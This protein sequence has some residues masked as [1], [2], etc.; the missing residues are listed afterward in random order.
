MNSATK[1]SESSR[2]PWRGI[3]HESRLEARRESL[4]AAGLE[5]LGTKGWEATTVRAVCAEAG[6]TSRYFY[7]NFGDL[8]DLLVTLFD[9][10]FT[11]TT[12][13]AYRAA[14]ADDIDLRC[15]VRAAV[16]ATIEY[17]TEDPRRLRVLAV[18]AIGNEQ[19]NRRRLDA[20][21][22]LAGFLDA[23]G[24][25][26]YGLPAGSEISRM[27]A[28]VLIGGIAELALAWLDGQF[29][30]SIAELA[31]NIVDLYIAFA[32]TAASLARTSSPP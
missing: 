1:V 25:Q 21:K 10:L 7:E 5:L 8:D 11:E 32:E 9:S 2:R 22:A 20:L 24:Q 19:L 4:L 13:R 18:E 3:A 15:R 6:L 12:A 30:S 31:D 17:V 27:T 16:G 28:H 23:Q 14:I 26:I 29:E